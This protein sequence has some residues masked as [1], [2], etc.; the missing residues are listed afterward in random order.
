MSHHNIQPDFCP[1]IFSCSYGRNKQIRRLAGRKQG[2]NILQLTEEPLAV[3]ALT[4]TIE[5]LHDVE[6]HWDH[7]VSKFNVLDP[8]KEASTKKSK[9]EI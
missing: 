4:F 8:I 7:L 9:S 1:P 6:C 5:K 3:P 2:R